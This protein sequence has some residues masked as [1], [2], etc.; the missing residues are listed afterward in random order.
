MHHLR[1]L[2]PRCQ[3]PTPVPC[4]ERVGRL[5]PPRTWRHRLEGRAPLRF[6]PPCLSHPDNKVRRRAQPRG[7]QRPPLRRHARPC[8]PPTLPCRRRTRLSSPRRRRSNSQAPPA[9][10]W[11][12]QGRS[13]RPV[14]RF[15]P[16]VLDGR[17]AGWPA[18]P[19]D[20]PI[21][22]KVSRTRPTWMVCPAVRVCCVPCRKRVPSR[23]TGLRPWISSSRN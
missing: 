3:P 6:A 16:A 5:G 15:A 17:S 4:R 1:P 7:R 10:R 19:A 9:L 23:Y 13:A 20:Y 11:K 18:R 14:A 2:K 8:P 21:R 12:R 22:L